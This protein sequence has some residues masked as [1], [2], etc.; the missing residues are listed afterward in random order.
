MMIKCRVLSYLPLSARSNH[1]S[2]LL[3]ALKNPRRAVKMARDAKIQQVQEAHECPTPCSKFPKQFFRKTQVNSNYSHSLYLVN[4]ET[5]AKIAQH[6]TKS[7]DLNKTFVETN[8]G[9]GLLTELLVKSGMTDLRLYEAIPEFVKDLQ[10]TY[11]QVYPDRVK[12]KHYDMVGLCRSI[13]FDQMTGSTRTA[14][15]L[16]ELPS[17]EWE[18]ETNFTLF[19]ATGSN[20]FFWHLIHSIIL[21][22]SIL[23]LGRCECYMVMPSV[24]Y[25][26]KC[27]LV[28]R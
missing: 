20:S 2:S 4:N 26:V 28:A 18:K 11:A 13:S 16:S 22:F 10:E 14:A 3:R 7:V 17:T 27:L 25:M 15:V 23:A 5:A 21:Q 6:L 24:V 8:P 1:N 19:G 12:L 9:E